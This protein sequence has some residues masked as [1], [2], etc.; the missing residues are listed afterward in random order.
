MRENRAFV[1][2]EMTPATAPAPHP[3]ARPP[4]DRKRP[5]GCREHASRTRT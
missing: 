5:I 2:F 1:G 4:G 3:K